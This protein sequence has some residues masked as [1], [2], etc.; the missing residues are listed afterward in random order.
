[1]KKFNFFPVLLVALFMFCGFE[2]N[3]QTFKPANEALQV[4]QSVIDQSQA[5]LEASSAVSPAAGQQLA[6]M[7]VRIELGTELLPLI[8]YSQNVSK[9]LNDIYAKYVNS[10]PKTAE[11]KTAL[12][13]IRSLLII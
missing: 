12:D 9:S 8:K 11:L 13:H 4:V 5:T 6:Q 7:V 1:M 2:S 10:D 3:A